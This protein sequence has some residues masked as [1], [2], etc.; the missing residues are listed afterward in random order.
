MS[1]SPEK[2]PY[3]FKVVPPSEDVQQ[4]VARRFTAM[5]SGLVSCNH[6]GYKLSG[7]STEQDLQELY[8]HPL[9]ARDTWV[10][11]PPKCGTNWT[12]EMVWLV[13]NDLDYERAKTPLKPDRY[14][15]RR[16]RA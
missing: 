14:L 16:R 15:F 2:K 8:N 9:D 6:W 5:P 7:T 12:M 1:S 4:R 10:V 13:A 11:T 3:P